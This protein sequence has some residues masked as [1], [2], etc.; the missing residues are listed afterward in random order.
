[1]ISLYD[2]RYFVPQWDEQMLGPTWRQKRGKW[3]FDNPPKPLPLTDPKMKGAF[4]YCHHCEMTWLVG[5][6]KPEGNQHPHHLAWEMKEDDVDVHR[7]GLEVEASLVIFIHGACIPEGQP[8]KSPTGNTAG[9]G[10]FFGEG[11][12]YNRAVPLGNKSSYEDAESAEIAAVDL[13]LAIVKYDILGDREIWLTAFAEEKRDAKEKEELA[14]L[15]TKSVSKT[16][17]SDDPTRAESIEV[18]E[19]E[20]DDDDSWEDDSEED[21][22]DDLDKL[23]FRIIIVSDKVQIVDNVCKHYKQWK[24]EKGKLLTKKGKPV[25]HGDKYQN[26]ILSQLVD[27]SDTTVKWYCVPKDQNKEAMKLAMEALKGNSV[28]FTG[29]V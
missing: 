27:D 18:T 4:K 6:D 10:I 12:Q 19:E 17:K 8:S 23:P 24:E 16:L 3:D 28:R 22:E 7:W 25:K 2:T 15:G 26:L 9:F 14:K 5:Y 20:D 13:A 21:E 11:S 29:E 1:M